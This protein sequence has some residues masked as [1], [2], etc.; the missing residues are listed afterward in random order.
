VSEAVKIL[1]VETNLGLRRGGVERL[2]SALL[3]LGLA[4]RLAAHGVESLR[5]PEFRQDRDPVS[6]TRN[7]PEIAQ[8]ASSQADKI[9]KILDENA[10]P[11]VLGGDDSVLI[12]CLLALR[13]RGSAGL[14]FM[15]GHTDF[16]DLPK[17]LAGEFSESDL[18]VATG[19][20]PDVVADLEGMRPLV[21]PR[22]CVVYGHRD[23]AEQIQQGSEDVYLQPMLVR[24]LAELR[25]AG[26]KDAGHHAAAFLAG[27]GVDRV[28]LHVDADCLDDAL[29]P[30]VD[31]RTSG[32]MRPSE[33]VDISRRL[34]ES[35]LVA[36]MDVTI[37]NPSLDTSDLDAGR[38]LLEVIGEIL[39]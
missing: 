32:G 8:L 14:M 37:Y 15:D 12:G 24:S 3:E 20:G 23:R 1:H 13:R 16:W 26:M 30:A 6:G 10:F 38:V 17:S 36:G 19:H 5:A 35:G 29:M 18:W 31:W 27:A 2:G 7:L 21:D 11:L 28:W 4:D 33:L 9:G 39:S 22:A 34:L 25:A